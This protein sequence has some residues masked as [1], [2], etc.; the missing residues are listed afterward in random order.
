MLLGFLWL[1]YKQKS[2]GGDA[3]TV[4]S[5][6]PW[7]ETLWQSGAHPVTSI[8]L[9]GQA[10]GGC[11]FAGMTGMHVIPRHLSRL[12]HRHADAHLRPPP[13]AGSP[14]APNPRHWELILRD[15]DFFKPTSMI[16]RREGGL[17]LGC[18]TCSS[19]A[20]V[21]QSPAVAGPSTRGAGCP[22]TGA[23]SSDGRREGGTAREGG[24]AALPLQGGRGGRSGHWSLGRMFCLLRTS[25]VW[26]ESLPLEATQGHRRGLL[27][28]SQL[29][30]YLPVQPR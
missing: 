21:L 16:H 4:P 28:S 26:Q 5:G 22:H 9:P 18:H 24:P 11:G 27:R 20:P 1:P 12:L 3:G 6:A 25:P 10:A 8:M 15:K 23:T 19:A 17:R 29:D 7:Q 30:D 14:A 13:T 2:Q